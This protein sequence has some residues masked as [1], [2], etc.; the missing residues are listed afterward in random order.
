M[1]NFGAVDI[2]GRRP[3]EVIGFFWRSV[4]IYIYVNFGGRRPGE[5]IGFF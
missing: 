3:G 1:I 5:V 4:Y 2:G